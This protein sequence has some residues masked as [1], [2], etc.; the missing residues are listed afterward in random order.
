MMGK[1]D[2]QLFADEIR[3]KQEELDCLSNL[4]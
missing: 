2:Y 1:K 4:K 3:L